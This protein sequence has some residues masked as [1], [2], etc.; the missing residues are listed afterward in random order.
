MFDGLPNK[1]LL[2][3]PEAGVCF[4]PDFLLKV[5]TSVGY[6]LLTGNGTKGP[7]TLYPVFVQTSFSWNILKKLKH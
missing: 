2:A 6:N 1:S 7:G 3:S 4:C 5:Q